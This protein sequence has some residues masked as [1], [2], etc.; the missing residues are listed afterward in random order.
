MRANAGKFCILAVAATALLGAAGSAGAQS[1]PATPELLLELNAATPS[2]KGCHLT[3][4]V[5]N[6]LGAELSRAAF[7]IA[8]FNQAGVVDRLT[9]LDFERLPAGKTKVTRFDLPGTDCTKVNRALVNQAT[10]CAG[11]GVE[12]SACLKLLRTES[13]SGIAFGI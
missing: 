9:V 2:D 5:S 13:K 1:A 11:P 8:L 10:D 3:F 6:R 4:V 7:E 12:P